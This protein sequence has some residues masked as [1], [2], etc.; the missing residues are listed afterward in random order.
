MKAALY[1]RT[2]GPEVLEWDDIETPRAGPGEVRVRVRAAGVQ[3]IDCA[4]RSGFTPAWLKP[5][6]PGIPG[7][8]FAGVVDQAGAGFEEGDEV[9]GF[10]FMRAAAE[11]V[12]VPAAQLTRKPAAMPWEVAGGFSGAAQTAHIAH[13]LLHPASGETMLVHGAAGAVGGVA[14][15]LASRSKTRVV[16]TAS[17]A[18]REYLRSLGVEPVVYGPG[19]AD[20]L[21]PLLPSGADVVLDGAGGEALDVS[22]ELCADRTRILTLADHGRAAELGVRTT[23]NLR[24]AGR[25][26]ELA[27]LYAAGELRFPIRRTYPMSEAAAAHREVE[28][29]HGRGK[30]VLVA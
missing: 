9:L 3:P 29:G 30:V 27:A 15:Q 6:L 1:R 21:R 26:A 10:G 22:L 12:V 19:L 4:V 13:E 8:E 11:Y 18:N 24:S 17:A 14:V 25:L 2:G 5:D 7:N 28:T 16:G 23:R 20:R